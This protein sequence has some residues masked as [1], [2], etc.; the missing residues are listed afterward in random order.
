MYVDDIL[1]LEETEEHAVLVREELTRHYEFVGMR[2]KMF[3][4]FFFKE[5]NPS[6]YTKRSLLS[7]IATMFDPLQF[8]A[9]YIIRAKMA[10]QEAWLRVLEWTI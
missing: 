5:I 10:L 7:R 8:L 2:V 3:S 6:L 9:S 1:H 4:S